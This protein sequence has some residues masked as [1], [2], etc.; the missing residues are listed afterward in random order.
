MKILPCVILLYLCFAIPLHAQKNSEIDVL[1]NRLKQKTRITETADIQNQI[2]ILYKN[3]NA[4]SA[5][6]YNNI[7]LETARTANDNNLL[8]SALKNRAIIFNLLADYEK[9]VNFAL[10]AASFAEKGN[11]KLLTAECM[12]TIGHI[13]YHKAENEMFRNKED[14]D[15]S[16]EYYNKALGISEELNDSLQIVNNWIEIGLVSFQ[17]GDIEKAVKFL[18][19]ALDISKRNSSHRDFFH[20]IAKASHNIGLVYTAGQEYELAAEN[21]IKAAEIDSILN[22]KEGVALIRYAEIMLC[23]GKYNQ[24]L[25]YAGNSYDT[26]IAYNFKL[27]AKQACEVMQQAYA[28]KGEYRMAYDIMLKYQAFSDSLY[29]EDFIKK[30]G[31]MELSHQFELQEQ[32]TEMKY[33]AEINRQKLMRNASLIGL[34]LTLLLIIVVVYAYLQK[35]KSNR[36][37]QVKNEQILQQKDEIEAQRDLAAQQRD[38][39]SE[40]K[41]E[42]TDSI[43][44]AFRIQSAVIPDEK[45]MSD[46]LSDYFVYYRPRDI[47]SGDFYWIGSIE[48]KLIII[49]A[50]CTGHGV[51]GAFMSMLGVAFLNDIVNKES[52]TDP[53]KILNRLRQEIVRALKQSDKAKEGGNF[54]SVKDGM[55]VAA[56]TINPSEKSLL[57]AGANNPLYLIKNKELVEIKGNKMPVAAYTVMDDFE[58]HEFPVSENDT[59]YIFSDGFADQFGGPEG[60][61]F[62][63]KPFKELLLSIQ[64]KPMRDQKT[65]L[66][67]TFENWK[68]YGGEHCEQIDDV[69]VVGIRI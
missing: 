5:L 51:P 56:I 39:I 19:D 17:L 11:N 63:Y 59:L 35:R 22:N 48:G 16:L 30:L 64:N 60:K 66:N 65:M 26:A 49:A 7:A 23:Q 67:E 18:N 1:K 61:K 6:H 40:Q 32:A 14:L 38:L 43:H 28:A 45:Y 50:D 25:Y 31:N 9:A 47:V 41:H 42:I 69:M 8:A 57:F 3:I 12:F 62:K 33:N 15:H 10:E 24:A 55:D 34:L 27:R 54:Q 37:L 21:F 2:S 36:I 13:Y 46:I 4:D 68:N 29:S 53:A 58:C 52:I 44:Y 20:N